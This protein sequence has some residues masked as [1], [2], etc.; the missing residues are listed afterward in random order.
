MKTPTTLEG[1]IET[2]QKKYEDE[3]RGCD[4]LAQINRYHNWERHEIVKSAGILF[5][6]EVRELSKSEALK[7]G[8]STGDGP[9]GGTF[10]FL[11]GETVYSYRTGMLV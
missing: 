8:I 6:D 9:N 10:A 4:S 2:I 1:L 7:H 5:P 11:V 3:R